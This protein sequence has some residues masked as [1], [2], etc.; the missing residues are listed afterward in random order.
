M[1]RSFCFA[2]LLLFIPFCPQA[3]TISTY[4][5]NGTFGYSGDGG[6]ATDAQMHQP[7]GIAA[8]TAGNI[9]FVE[10]SGFV[11]R[12]V[13]PAG[14]IS[15]YAGDGTMGSTGDGGPATAAKVRPIV[16]IATDIAG[17]VY[18]SEANDNRL[19]KVNASTGIITTFAGDGGVT[20][21]GDGVAATAAGLRSPQGVC[22]DTAGI[23][24]VASD[25]RIYKIDK[26]GIISTIAGTG[27]AGSTGDNGPATDATIGPTPFLTTDLAG[28]LYFANTA[29]IS[30]SRIRKISKNGIIT[31]VA[32][33]G[34]YGYSG[35]GGPATDATFRNPGGVWVDSCANIYIADMLNAVIRKVDGYTGIITT[36]VGNGTTGAGGEGV[37][38]TASAMSRPLAITMDVDNNFFITEAY[39][40]R[41]RKIALPA[42]IGPGFPPASVRNVMTDIEVGIYPNPVRDALRILIKCESN[43]L[44]SAKIT[45]ITGRTLRLYKIPPNKELSIAPELPIG[46][47]L[48]LIDTREGTITKKI[49]IAP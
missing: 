41:I 36:V 33:T 49:Q 19:R 20:Y 48:L 35:D 45:D 4:A 32:G 24:Y 2:V 17:N 5:G 23:I 37:P 15:T 26:A 42:C 12:K 34:A 31:T 14:I 28:N 21:P 44:L 29:T 9:Y 43:D 10:S 7:G 30:A 3:Q 18:F 39:G 6:P 8:D 1:N 16:S 22:V 27:V 47:Y 40:Y 46:Y 25:Y 13:S 38:A 11:I